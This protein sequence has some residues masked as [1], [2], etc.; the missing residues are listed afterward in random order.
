MHML[1][2]L[3]CGKQQPPHF[4]MQNEG[5]S[6]LISSFCFVLLQFFLLSMFFISIFEVTLTLSPHIFINFEFHGFQ[7]GIQN[8]ISIGFIDNMTLFWTSLLVN[9]FHNSNILRNERINV[10]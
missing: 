10:L 2:T 4:P 7:H 5:P 9:E 3:C 1:I 8:R 6:Y